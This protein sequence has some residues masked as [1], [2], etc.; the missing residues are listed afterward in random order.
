MQVIRINP[1]CKPELT[2]LPNT[3][4]AYQQAVG[5]HIEA[6]TIARSDLPALVVILNEDGRLMGLPANGRLYLGHL[7]GQTLMGPVVIVRA[8]ESGEDFAG[9]TDNDLRLV[10]ALWNPVKRGARR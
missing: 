9:A 5:G 7:W 1:G 8:D 10:A 4:R 3:L 2:E 6:H